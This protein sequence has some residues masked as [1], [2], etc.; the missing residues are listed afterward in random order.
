MTPSLAPLLVLAEVHPSVLLLFGVAILWYVA[1]RAATDALAGS[2]PGGTPGRRAI[3]HWM[4]VV[5]V[6]M[7]AIAKGEPALALGVVFASS[8]AALSLVLGVVTLTTPPALIAV[9]A[10]RKWAF[11]LPAALLAL[12]AGF[13]GELT[14]THA[15]AFAVEGLA[16]LL[17]WRDR[18]ANVLAA[19]LPD[20]ET[21]I[22]TSGQAQTMR[23]GWLSPVQIVLALFLAA[24]GAVGALWGA[25]DLAGKWNVAGPG[26]VATLL[27]GPSL[28]LPMVGSGTMLAHRG[29]YTA[30]ISML[31]GFVLLNLCALLPALIVTWHLTH[32]TAASAASAGTP[33]ATAAA[34]VQG[35][36]AHDPPL[37]YSMSVWRVDTVVLLVVGVFLLP[38]SIGRWMPGKIEAAALIL[39][40]VIYLAMASAAA[41]GR[42]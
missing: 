28:V 11:V 8:V 38:V 1:A 26:I 40:Y 12:L 29:Q 20:P 19:A 4:P 31:V 37:I 10:R 18:P 36:F 25:H 21:A 15:L 39:G 41:G 34:Y 17:L 30:A 35:M 3:A 27:L 32:A 6:A 24:L 5:I 13:R 9:D 42:I 33:L 7:Y 14:L 23:P 2:D 16:L 22:E